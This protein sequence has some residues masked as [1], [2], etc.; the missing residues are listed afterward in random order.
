[1]AD[2][3]NL[4]RP[5]VDSMEK[6]IKCVYYNWNKIPDYCEYQI[7]NEMRI[8]NSLSLP[9]GETRKNTIYLNINQSSCHTIV[10]G[11][12]GGGKSNCIKVIL[13]NLLNLYSNVDIYLLD[14]KAVELNMFKDIYQCKMYEYD[15]D[16]ITEALNNLYNM[17]IDKYQS[18]MSKKKYKASVYDKTSI[19]FVEEISLASK[20]DIKTLQKI[21]AISRAVN[22]Y[23]VLSTQRASAND[24][25]SPT[26]KSLI[27]N[28]ICYKTSNKATSVVCIGEEGAELL[29]QVGRAYLKTDDSLVKFQTYHITDDI[30][31][32]VL[33]NNSPHIH[34]KESVQ[35][36]E[37][38]LSNL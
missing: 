24:V 29:K 19:L 14:Y 30:L 2:N 13:A 22:F 7:I 38:W 35:D 32:K 10:C 26:L 27:S 17:I 12:T 36:D 15:S 20:Q 4:L 8:G 6:F 3:N 16:K 5:L 9:I 21:L 23:V 33:E 31:E 18:M 28:T 37:S 1:M 11:Q 34:L 25:L